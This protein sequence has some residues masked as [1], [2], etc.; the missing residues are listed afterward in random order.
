MTSWDPVAMSAMHYQHLGLGA[1]IVESEGWQRPERYTSA[2]DELDRVRQAV[3]LCDI[4]PVGKLMVQGEAVT[5]L[6][7]AAF[8]DIRRLDVGR[9][10]ETRLDGQS[11]AGGVLVCR[12]ADDELL[13]LTG[14]GQAHSILESLSQAVDQC[15]HALDIT[16][17]L[18]GVKIAGPRAHRL[19]AAVTEIDT[20]ARAFSNMSCAQAKVAEVHGTLLRRDEGSLHSFELY[21][22][23]EYGEYMWDALTE[24]GETYGVAPFGIEALRRLGLGE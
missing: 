7:G 18:A 11:G 2:D 5:A 3:G 22:E 4:S 10:R 19:M 20:S 14:P 15:V 16:S 23:R 8:V 21:V 13:V 12:L 6:F 9:A 17:A 24:A 1:V